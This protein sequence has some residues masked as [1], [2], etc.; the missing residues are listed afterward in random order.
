MKL[1]NETKIVATPKY[2]DDIFYILAV[3]DLNQNTHGDDDL[4]K[5]SVRAY[6]LVNELFKNLGVK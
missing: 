6:K 4:N 1:T 2:L 5:Q 3:L